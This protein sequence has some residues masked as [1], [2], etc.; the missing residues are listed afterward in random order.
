MFTASARVAVVS[1][2]V[3]RADP[4]VWIATVFAPVAASVSAGPVRELEA[5]RARESGSFGCGCRERDRV[6]T[7]RR[8]REIRRG[9]QNIIN[10]ENIVFIY[11]FFLTRSL[12]NTAS[13]NSHKYRIANFFKSLI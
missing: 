10:L 8:E 11:Y 4:L 6:R 9:G 2:S 12:I 5:L 1:A 3:S 13:F 7:R